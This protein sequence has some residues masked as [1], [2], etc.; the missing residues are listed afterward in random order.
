MDAAVV[1]FLQAVCMAVWGCS[2][3]TGPEP[4]VRYSAI[5][6]ASCAK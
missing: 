1:G 3:L 2:N 5:M 4:L 6:Q